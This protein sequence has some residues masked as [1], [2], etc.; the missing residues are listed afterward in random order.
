M[1]TRLTEAFRIEHPS[2]CAPMALVTGGRLAAAVSRAGG[3]V[4]TR[5]E[6][7]Y[8]ARPTDADRMLQ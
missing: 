4:L 6:I 1:R 7:H 8:G 5:I 2:E 3:G